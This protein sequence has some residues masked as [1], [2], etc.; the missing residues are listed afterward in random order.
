MMRDFYHQ[1]AATELPEAVLRVMWDDLKRGTCRERDAR[2]E[3]IDNRVLQWMASHGIAEEAVFWDLREL[4]GASGEKF[5]AFWD[6]LG[7]YLELEVGSAAHGRRA[8]EAHD[9]VYA[10]APPPAWPRSAAPRRS[11][12]SRRGPCAGVARRCGTGGDRGRPRGWRGPG[13]RR[14]ARAS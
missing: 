7:A 5:N 14:R 1:Y 2:Q 10:P 13:R 12:P 6:E 4:N 11:A 8:A 3:V 9:V